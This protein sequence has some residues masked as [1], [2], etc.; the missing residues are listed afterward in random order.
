MRERNTRNAVISVLTDL[1]G[2]T[3]LV[4]EPS[5]PAD[6]GGYGIGTGYG[7]VG[8]AEETPEA[9]LR[10][11]METNFFGAMWVTQAALPVLRRGGGGHILQVSSIGGICAFPMIGAYHASKWAL[12]GIS[13]SLAQEVASFNIKVTMIEPTGFSTDWGG[14]SAKHAERLAAYDE[15]REGFLEAR[16]NRMGQPGGPGD[17]GATAAAVL[18]VVDADDPP[19]RIFFGDGPLAMATADYEQRLATWRQWEPISIAAHGAR[20]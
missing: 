5:R 7:V 1:T 14:P 11:Q 8:A 19:L 9:E 2:R 18:A 6:T 3:P 10:A 16:R 12:E 20:P 17:P 4:F 15:V 13:Q